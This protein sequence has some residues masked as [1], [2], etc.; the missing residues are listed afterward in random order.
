MELKSLQ[1]KYNAVVKFTADLTAERDLIFD[2][3]ESTQKELLK[4]KNKNK[5]AG[6][7]GSKGDEDTQK[8]NESGN[9]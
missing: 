8:K 5:E 7:N 9:R 4:E 1:Q 3:L 6:T 2:Q